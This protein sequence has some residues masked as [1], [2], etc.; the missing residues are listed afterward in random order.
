M[1]PFFSRRAA[2]A[3][4]KVLIVDDHPTHQ[5]LAS[6][7]FRAF[8]CEVEVSGNGIDATE[9][10]RQTAFDLI[11]LDRHM[12]G[13][14]GDHVARKVREPDSASARAVIVSHTTD[15]P[16]GPAAALYDRVIPKPMTIPA[17]LEVAE[18]ARAARRKGKA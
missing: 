8:D 13:A 5:R 18:T 7:L 11:V 4:V 1:P 16:A 9:R 3:P 6:T 2:P 17:M 12:P 14:N 10:A 15:P